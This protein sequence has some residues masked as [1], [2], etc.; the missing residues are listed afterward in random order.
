MVILNLLWV[1]CSLPIF[2]MGAA[3]TALHAM[4]IK[5]VQNREKGVFTGF[6]HAF[7]ENFRQ[8]TLVWLPTLVVG[9]ILVVD[10]YVCS[11]M[12][13]GAASPL[14]IAIIA[15][16]VVLVAFGAYIFPVLAVFQNPLKKAVKN[17]FIMAFGYL[18]KT[19][20][21]LLIGFIPVLVF[22]ASASNMVLGLFVL[23]IA[24]ASFPAWLAA[25]VYNKVFAKCTVGVQ[26][27]SLI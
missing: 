18:P 16:M 25:R 17:S 27:P 4:T 19:L 2:T 22:F 3:T 11:R 10:L 12:D 15:L 7:R 8:A 5:L 9:I 21:L 23:V 6:F 13:N 24:G 14:C 26:T 1:V 20:L